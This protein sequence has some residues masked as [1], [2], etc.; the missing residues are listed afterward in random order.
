MRRFKDAFNPGSE[1]ERR[2]NQKPMAR[3]VEIKLK[4][5]RERLARKD[6]AEQQKAALDTV[7]NRGAN[8]PASP[9]NSVEQRQ[10]N[11]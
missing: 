6:A 1:N 3:S 9:S 5:L 7:L 11:T 10:K 4:K 2:A 8:A